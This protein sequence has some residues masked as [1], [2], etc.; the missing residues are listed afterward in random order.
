MVTVFDRFVWLRNRFAPGKALSVFAEASDVSHATISQLYARNRRKVRPDI[1]P[2]RAE[3]WSKI[4]A[5]WGVRLAWLTSGDGQP[6]DDVAVDETELEG[7]APEIGR[8]SPGSGS[9]LAA[10]I[11]SS[12]LPP[13][14]L[15]GREIPDQVRADAA[16]FL[17][18][19]KHPSDPDRYFTRDEIWA[20]F[21]NVTIKNAGD[22]NSATAVAGAVMATIT[23]ANDEPLRR[24]SPSDRAARRRDP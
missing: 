19:R 15:R 10:K 21:R 16:T 22:A 24:R 6:F 20:G 7:L 11:V 5:K 8:S 17:L 14:P 1:A 2:G 23:G 3:T 13:Q 18:A 9:F 12:A 4:A